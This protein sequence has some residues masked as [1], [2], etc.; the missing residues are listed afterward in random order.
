MGCP[1]ATNG[2]LTYDKWGAQLRQIGCYHEEW[3]PM[4]SMTLVLILCRN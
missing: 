4:R 3:G 2:V 1:V